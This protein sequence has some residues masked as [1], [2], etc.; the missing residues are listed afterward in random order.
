[1][2][3][4]TVDG[5]LGSGIAARASETG[6]LVQTAESRAAALRALDEG[7]RVC[8][9]IVQARLPDGSGRDVI[10]RLA[11]R[12]PQRPPMLVLLDADAELD[13]FARLDVPLLHCPPD[14][15]MI[16]L[17]LEHN[18]WRA[19]RCALAWRAEDLDLRGPVSQL[20]LCEGT[21]M[22]GAALERA[23]GAAPSTLSGMRKRFEQR[24][25]SSIREQVRLAQRI[26]KRP[27]PPPRGGHSSDRRIRCCSSP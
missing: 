10:V 14:W 7:A 19:L 18:E 15:T 17:W 8:A 26:F 12:A 13:E 2:L 5:D 9:A 25:G 23:L 24:Y 20:L 3:L 1:M 27:P 4:V 21:G 11:T 16:Q 6:Y 22:R